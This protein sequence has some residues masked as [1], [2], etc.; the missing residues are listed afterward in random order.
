MTEADLEPKVSETVKGKVGFPQL[1]PLLWTG[2]EP[3]PGEA[4]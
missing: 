2:P 1:L 4:P 3:L